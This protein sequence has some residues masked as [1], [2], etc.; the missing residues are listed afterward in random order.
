MAF[1]LRKPGSPGQFLTRK[2]STVRGAVHAFV[3][4]PTEVTHFHQRH[5][6][7][8]LLGM[9]FLDR[10]FCIFRGHHRAALLP[11]DR[12]GGPGSHN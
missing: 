9:K 8:K 11:K 7:F 10:T 4:F 3:H 2:M 6:L 12:P 5:R 1:I